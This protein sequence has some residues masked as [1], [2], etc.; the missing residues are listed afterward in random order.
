[1]TTH[2]QTTEAEPA[3][4]KMPWT[5]DELAELLKAE[6]PSLGTEE[7]DVSGAEI[8]QRLKEM[9]LEAGGK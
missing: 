6:F 2:Q 3:L 7:E 1:M 4:L 5:A 8:A 9:Y